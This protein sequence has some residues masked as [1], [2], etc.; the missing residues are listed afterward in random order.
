MLPAGGRHRGGYTKKAQ[1]AST[2]SARPPGL[3]KIIKKSDMPYRQFRHEGAREI[4]KNQFKRKNRSENLAVT[5]KTA[6]FAPR[7]TGLRET[8]AHR[9]GHSPAGLERC[10]HIAEVPGSNPGVPTSVRH[11]KEYGR[12]FIAFH[13]S[14]PR[15]SPT[16]GWGTR[17]QKAHPAP[18]KSK[19]IAFSLVNTATVHKFAPTSREPTSRSYP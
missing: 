11:L 2:G 16:A 10:S 14:A 1:C 9:K 12:F 19:K 6:N 15:A 8:A 5:A 4:G 7:Q 13:H 18:K 3:R 17:D